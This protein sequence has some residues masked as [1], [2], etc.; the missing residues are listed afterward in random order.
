MRVRDGKSNIA[1]DW[2]Y[3]LSQSETS[4]VTLA[5]QDDLYH[6]LYGQ[7]MRQLAEI[8]PDALI[9]FTNN[10]LLIEGQRVR[11][12]INLTIQRTLLWPF[13]FRRGI[14]SRFVR[15]MTL[16]FGNPIC[17]PSVTY[18]IRNLNRLPGGF[19]FDTTFP[20]NLDWEAWIRLARQKG[21]FAYSPDILMT[22]RFHRDSETSSSLAGN[23]RQQDDRRIFRLL[24]PKPIAA[25]I[26]GLYALAYQSKHQ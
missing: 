6:P 14:R 13:R 16:S 8:H 10:D 9:L 1:D 15:R 4:L 19:S 18:S 23:R 12:T 22:H 11:R 7:Q 3:A 26:A 25:V 17:C 21:S 2:N 5:H 24:W 20:N